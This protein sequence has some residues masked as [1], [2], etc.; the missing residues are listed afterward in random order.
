MN[1]DFNTYLKSHPEMTNFYNIDESNFTR[2]NLAAE[3]WK[4]RNDFNVIQLNLISS[5]CD[6]FKIKKLILI[7]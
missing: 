5:M 3:I 6:N 1:L 4:N 2:R 7:I